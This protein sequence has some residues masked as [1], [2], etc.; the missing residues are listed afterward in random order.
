MNH[1]HDLRGIL[2]GFK[3][4][5]DINEPILPKFDNDNPEYL[6]DH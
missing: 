5:E 3:I 6:C 4:Y 2:S 1:T